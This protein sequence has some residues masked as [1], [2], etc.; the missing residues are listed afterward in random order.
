MG[1]VVPA[2]ITFVGD[3][4]PDAEFGLVGPWGSDA[5]VANLES[6]IFEPKAALRPKAYSVVLGADAFERI[7]RSGAAA[8]NVANNHVYDAGAAAFDEMLTRLRRL[9]GPQFYGLRERPNA[10]IQVG[11]VSCAIIGC[12]E[13]CRARGPELLPEEAVEALIPTLLE[14]HGRVYVTP[15]WGMEGELAF[16]PSPRQRALARRW[17]AAGAS[18]VFGHHSHTIHG[19]ESVLG[20]PVYYSLGNFQFDH[21]E[22]R[23]YPAAAWGLAVQV[24]PAGAAGSERVEFFLQEAGRVIPADAEARVLL[25]GHLE[26][27]SAELEHVAD[28]AWQWAR[29]VGPVYMSKC[30]KSWRIRASRSPLRTAALWC[31]WNLL[32]RTILLR[33]GCC[34]PDGDAVRYRQEMNRLLL[35]AQA[36]LSSASR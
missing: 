13:P 22:G 7:E 34:M 18:G 6:V 36:R 28:R 1:D 26:R 24:D 17:I 11:S 16:H 4:F 14:Q 31:A 5:V 12:L 15:H 20:R 3:Y 19:R 8:F 10:V 35:E 27:I 21:A 25:E 9:S 2:R 29:T 33:L 23:E 30:R 32:P